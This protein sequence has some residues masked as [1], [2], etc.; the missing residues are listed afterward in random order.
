[1]AFTDRIITTHIYEAL[2]R[3]P[4]RILKDNEILVD[5]LPGTDTAVM[6]LAFCHTPGLIYIQPNGTLAAAL[7]AHYNIDTVIY[8]R[9]VATPMRGYNLP[10]R[11]AATAQ[12]GI[13]PINP[14]GADL[15][16]TD[17]QSGCTVLILDL[18]G[19]NYQ[20]VHLQPYIDNQYNKIG[21]SLLDGWG[22]YFTKGYSRLFYQNFWLKRDA[23]QTTNNTGNVPERYIMI[24]SM[25]AACDG[26]ASQ[27]IGIRNANGWHFFLQRSYRR[28]LEV[29]ELRWTNY[30][31]YLPYFSY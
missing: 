27:V 22:N 13:A 30:N 14:T 6:R 18:G 15:W 3:Y 29:K 9:M 17:A 4:L 28:N 24:E 12:Q 1:M 31:S 26:K 8:R 2:T 19:N 10:N 5:N 23:T 20:M 7:V 16:V 25:H 21:Q 11:Q